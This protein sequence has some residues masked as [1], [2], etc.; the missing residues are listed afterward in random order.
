MRSAC[1]RLSPGSRATRRCTTSS[2]ATPRSSRALRSAS[3]SPLRRSRP[4][5][6]RRS[7]RATPASMREMLGERMDRYDV[8]VWLV[9]TGW[10]GGPYGIGERMNIN[11]TRQMVRAALSGRSTTSR[12]GP[13][14]IFGF[15]V[16]V[17][18]PG[19]TDRGALAARH[20]GR[21]SR[22]RRPGAQ[23]RD[24][25]RRELQA[26]RGPRLRCHPRGRPAPALAVQRLRL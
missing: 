12:R 16:P 26:L 1:C 19:R 17:H 8:P 24:H 18:V 2:V 20:V 25:V 22:L 3:R 9:N 6:A 4:A 14:P 5:L 23:A 21:Q 7:C 13:I 11:L 15:Q 10:T